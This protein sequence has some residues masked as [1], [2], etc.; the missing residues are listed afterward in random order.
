MLL[1]IGPTVLRRSCLDLFGREQ[2][3][4]CFPLLEF[5]G[6]DTNSPR[7]FGNAEVGPTQNG[8]AFSTVLV[9]FFLGHCRGEHLLMPMLA[10]DCDL[11]N[12]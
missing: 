6:E 2:A 8:L 10:T 3:E 12:V 11:A 1:N 5:A 7:K 4:S 9:D